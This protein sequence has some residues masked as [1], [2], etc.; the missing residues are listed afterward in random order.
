MVARICLSLVSLWTAL[1]SGW[2]SSPHALSLRID[3]SRPRTL[4]Q[5]NDIY[6]LENDD[7]MQT[8]IS[9]STSRAVPMLCTVLEMRC[10]AENDIQMQVGAAAD[11]VACHMPRCC[12]SGASFKY[13]LELFMFCSPLPAPRQRATIQLTIASLCLH[14]WCGGRGR[15]SS[16]Q[17]VEVA[18]VPLHAFKCAR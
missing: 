18:A 12:S 15:S 6:G 4:Q 13:S 16:R 3:R 2:R 14:H 8:C 7:K 5:R 9:W 1:R 17:Q 11:D 10:D